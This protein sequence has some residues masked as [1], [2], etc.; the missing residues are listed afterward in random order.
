MSRGWWGVSAVT[1]LGFFFSVAVLP[2]QW[3]TYLSCLFGIGFIFCVVMAFFAKNKSKDG[4]TSVMAKIS[5]GHVMQNI[6]GR[7]AIHSEYHYHS[8]HADP[9][10]MRVDASALR[11]FKKHRDNGEK[12]LQSIRPNDGSSEAEWAKIDEWW[13][14]AIAKANQK[15]FASFLTLKDLAT[16]QEPWLGDDKL[17]ALAK[18]V[19]A[20]QINDNNDDVKLY[21]CHWERLERLRQL[22]GVI[23][24]G[25]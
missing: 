15:V 21:L 20:G 6:A 16:L 25:Q 4:E 1:L 8:D 18:A 24:R 19:D 3:K 2:E 9:F 22:I 23:V 13:T 7:D 11:D 17:T 10:G 12:I 14:E 5:G